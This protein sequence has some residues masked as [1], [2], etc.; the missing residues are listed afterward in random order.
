MSVKV[1][2]IADSACDLPREQAAKL[3]VELLPL[4]TV[5]GDKEYLDG[6][7]MS[8]R[9]FYEMLVETDE[10]PHTSQVTPAQYEE[11]FRHLEPGEEAVCVTLSAKLSGTYNSARL[12]M[13]D[14]PGKVQLMDSETVC[15]GEQLL[16]RLAVRL[17]DRGLSAPEIAAE[18]EREKKRVHVLGLLDTLEYL[19][20]GGRLSSTAAFAGGLLSIKPVVTTVNGEVT[21]L[22]K[23]RGSKNGNNL[24]RSFIEQAGGIDFSMPYALAY[25]GLSDALLQ[26]YL[27]DS[28]SLYEGKAEEIPICAIGSTIGTYA[29]P[30]A[31]AV[32][33]FGRR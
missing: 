6:V 33:F 29:G 32:A 25:S 23:A 15:I 28:A 21:V 19:K 11:A 14:F 7:T 9:Q 3:G 1:K 4:T 12:A 18:L 16:V 13:A 8:S 2:I 20:K 24:L 26:K 10:L 30:G 17:R 22:G 5:F 31:I 27:A